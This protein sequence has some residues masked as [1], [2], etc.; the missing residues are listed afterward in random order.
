VR[1]NTESRLQALKIAF[2][3]L[4]GLALLAVFPCGRLPDYR[5]GEIPSDQARGITEPGERKSA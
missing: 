3:I 5:P 2:F 4:A 1:I